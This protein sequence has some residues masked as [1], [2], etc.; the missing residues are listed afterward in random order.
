MRIN[1]ANNQTKEYCEQDGELRLLSPYWTLDAE[2]FSR[3]A[4]RTEKMLRAVLP[5]MDD[6]VLDDNCLIRVTEL[7]AILNRYESHFHNNN[8][9][10]DEYQLNDLIYLI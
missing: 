3:E 8:S 2:N 4:Y 1:Y 7:P 6:R 5:H 9:S 10:E